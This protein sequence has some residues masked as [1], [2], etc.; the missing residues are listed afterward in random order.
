MSE[1]ADT[2]SI[3]TVIAS[4]ERQFPERPRVEIAEIVKRTYHQFDGAPVRDYV[5]VLAQREA[6]DQLRELAWAPHCP[7][8]TGRVPPRLE[9]GFWRN[10]HL[11]QRP[12]PC[13]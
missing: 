12:A 1:S 13:N 10:N 8:V 6:R 2:K 7:L 11:R 5:R 4:L 9:Q 3:S